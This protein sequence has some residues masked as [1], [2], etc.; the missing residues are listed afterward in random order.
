MYK[1][2]RRRKWRAG[3]RRRRYGRYRRHWRR[4]RYFHG[5]TAQRRRVVQWVPRRRRY[6]YVRGWEPLGNLCMTDYASTE[7]K[8]Y[9]SLEQPGSGQWH[10]TWGKHYFTPNN[11]LLRASAYWNQW[12]D[13]WAG[14]DYISIGGG[15]IYIPKDKQVE[16]MIN[17][18]PYL[19]Q[20]SVLGSKN[21]NED[22]WVHPGV[23]LNTPGT[24]LIMPPTMYQRKDFY[25]IK[26]RPPPGW[27]G[28]QRFPEAMGFILLH[29][30]WSWFNLQH[31]FFYPNYGVE[32][33][34]CEQEPWWGGNN[35]WN[36]WVDRSSYTT[37]TTNL[38]Q[39]TW[40]PFL[41]CKFGQNGPETSLMFFY[42]L[43][44]TFSG[45]SLWRP[46]PRNYANDGLVPVPP[47]PTS[48]QTN[49]RSSRKKKRP[50]HE[51]D[52]WPEDLDS[53]GLLTERAYQRITG[54]NPG[55]KRCKIRVPEQREQQRL[56][57]L[58]DRVKRVLRDRHLI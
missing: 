28:Y 16:W 48:D 14:Y 55:A 4:R 7:A 6:V 29:W 20:L 10:G 43:K 36:K 54:Y 49:T 34:T 21:N 44:F 13:D 27:V 47:G 45:N 56:K 26:L 53:D 40:G 15:T 51:A 35:Q 57:H 9:A 5:G 17:F 22:R 46:L 3:P 30:A 24:H 52:I 8:P 58:A 23:L 11:L 12:S 18:D 31:A 41:P 37:C 19:Q 2:R 33:S 50:L 39:K 25:K 42:K 32:T 38:P 1:R